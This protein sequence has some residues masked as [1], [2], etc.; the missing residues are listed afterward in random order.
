MKCAE[1]A[2]RIA[3]LCPQSS[4]VEVARLTTLMLTS[5]HESNEL[6]DCETF[7]RLWQDVNLRLQAANDQHDAMTCELEE[8]AK[9]D[10]QKFSADQ[11]WILVRAIKVQSQMLKMY[12]GD[13]MFEV[14]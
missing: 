4:C 12:I 6:Q 9:S 8:L 13:P 14:T 7:E 3:E 10:P 1:L 2:A 5:C 11:I